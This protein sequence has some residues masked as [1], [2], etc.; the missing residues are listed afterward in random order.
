[1]T[2]TELIKDMLERQ[3]ILEIQEMP[4]QQK[5]SNQLQNQERRSVS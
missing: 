4:K 2:R 1:M 5:S 3:K